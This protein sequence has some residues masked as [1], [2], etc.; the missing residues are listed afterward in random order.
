MWE[1]FLCFLV[2]LWK[3]PVWFVV[4]VTPDMC[5]ISFLL[6]LNLAFVPTFGLNSH[7]CLVSNSFKVEYIRFLSWYPGRNRFLIVACQKQTVIWF[8]NN[9]QGW[10]HSMFT[11]VS[12]MQWISYRGTLEDPLPPIFEKNS[13]TH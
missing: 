2:M 3:Q 12:W 5:F 9:F 13:S 10:I 6:G 8:S 7:R 11:V 4:W 1:T